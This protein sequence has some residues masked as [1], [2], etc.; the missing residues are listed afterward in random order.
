MDDLETNSASTLTGDIEEPL[1]NNNSS[2]MEKT[3]E[4]EN[5]PQKIE[6]RSTAWI[7]QTLKQILQLPKMPNLPTDIKQLPHILQQFR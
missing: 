2:V 3:P 4:L 1:E 5:L 6:C 7:D